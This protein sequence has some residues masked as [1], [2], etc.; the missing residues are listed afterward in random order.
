M[1]RFQPAI[2]GVQFDEVIPELAPAARNKITRGISSLLNKRFRKARSAIKGL[3]KVEFSDPD[4]LSAVISAEC[5]LNNWHSIGG[6]GIHPHPPETLGELTESL[7][8][9][10]QDVSEFS[11]VA[12]FTTPL[13]ELPYGEVQSA[14]QDLEKERTYLM[15]FPRLKNLEQ[16]LRDYGMTQALDDISALNLTGKSAGQALEYAWLSSVLDR[17]SIIQPALSSFDVESQSRIVTEFASSDKEHIQSSADRV[18]RAWATKAVL[19]R[20]DHPQAAAIVARQANLRRNH[21]PMRELFESASEVLTA[22]KPCWVMSPLVV[23]QVL[24]AKKCFDVVIFD[25]ASQILPADAISTLLRG[26]QA[27]VAGDPHQL[28]PSTFFISGTQDDPSESDQD[29]TEDGILSDLTIEGIATGRDIALTKDL[30]SVLD[31]MRTLLP[32]PYG[33]RTLEWHYRSRDERLITFSNAQ[34][35][36]YDWSLTTFPGARSDECLQHVLVPFQANQSGPTASINAEVDVVVE[37]IISHARQRPNE[38]LGV[39]A[40]GSVHSDR[41]ADR[42]RAKIGDHDELEEFFS[43]DRIEPFFVKNL[44]RVQGDERDAMILTIGYGKTMDGRMRYNFGPVNNEGGERRLNVAITRAKARMTVVSSF[45]GREMDPE[46]L[47]N[48]GPQMLRDYLLYAESGGTNLGIRARTKPAMNP[49]ERDVYDYLSAAGIPLIPQ[50]GQSGYWIDFAAMHPERKSEPVLAI[51]SDGAQYHSGRSA[52]DRDRIRQ[53]HLENLGWEFLRIWSTN[54][55]RFREKE[56][57]RCLEAF[58]AAVLKID[59][60]SSDAVAD[61]EPV[62]PKGSVSNRDIPSRSPWPGVR[63][64]LPINRYS[65]YE[66]RLVIQWVKSDGLLRTEN[67]IESEVVEAL[68]FKKRGSRIMESIKKAMSAE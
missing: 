9:L 64:R 52:R 22:I 18:K 28:P 37:L 60:R 4:L 33:T 12:G 7:K 66:I 45:S 58:R 40:L 27:I 63:R 57:A 46:R 67:E 59:S 68:G 8:K 51:E 41:I 53:Q 43:E 32:P 29:E 1:E 65:T 61:S 2:F 34:Q 31:V 48:I 5:A 30:D 11:D 62:G 13:A 55:F 23:A 25:E 56:I 19:A 6:E 16:Q 38:S 24:P 39:V 17:I 14:L 42:L 50:F 47:N 10:F 21:L 3:S 54:W 26:R 20:D 35:S 49:F 15:R 44:E 36:L